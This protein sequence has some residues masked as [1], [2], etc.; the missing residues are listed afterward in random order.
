VQ[1][2]LDLVGEI[3]KTYYL[4][5]EECGKLTVVNWVIGVLN[6][7]AHTERTTLSPETLVDGLNRIFLSTYCGR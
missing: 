2:E 1:V 7:I 6:S 4:D 3:E 5:V